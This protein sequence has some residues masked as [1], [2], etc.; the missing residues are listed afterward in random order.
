M[1][2]RFALDAAVLG[3]IRAKLEARC[4]RPA[5]EQRVSDVYLDT[6]D[7]ALAALGVAL[8][9]RRR[10]M[11][12]TADT[13]RRWR[14]QELWPRDAEPRSLGKLGVKRLKQRIDATFAVR[15]ERWTWKLDSD[16]GTVTLEHGEV[17]TGAATEAFSE[18]RVTCRRK[19]ADR[20]LRVAGELGATCLTVTKVRD[21]GH[22][23]LRASASPG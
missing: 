14:R 10:T 23:L 2:L 21:R 19:H 9:Y 8:R 7:D 6:P 11:V 4:E 12:G 5:I 20:A 3:S 16:L 17:S 1:K 22:A 15:T 13:A 18:M